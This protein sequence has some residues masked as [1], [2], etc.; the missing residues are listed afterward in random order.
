MA[1]IR[2]DFNFTNLTVLIQH[3]QFADFVWN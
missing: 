2:K 3:D 1:D